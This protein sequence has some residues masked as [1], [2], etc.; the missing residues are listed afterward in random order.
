MNTNSK[1]M[2]TQC[3]K[4]WENHKYQIIKWGFLLVNFCLLVLLTISVKL[5]WEEVVQNCLM[6]TILLL[7]L[8][9]VFY[10]L[11]KRE[12]STKSELVIVGICVLLILIS[13]IVFGAYSTGIYREP[14]IQI[15]AAFVGGAITLYGVGLTIK[16]NRLAK[17]QD[18]IEKAKPNIFPID[19]QTWKSLEG[20]AKL[21]RDI[22]PQLELSSLKKTNNN[23]NAYSFAPIYLANSDLSM[24]T[25]KGIVINDK[26]YIVFKYDVVL[27]KGSTNCFKLDY[28]FELKEDINSIQLVVGDM[29]GNTYACLVSFEYGSDKRKK[30][31]QIHIMGTLET[32][33][34][35]KNLAN[36]F[37]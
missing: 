32:K 20:I 28:C 19:P 23:T 3:T 16:Y 6:A 21:E 5:P 15:S 31:K 29:L 10:P 33:P 34:L 25:L 12:K 14:F 30:F 27:L 4:W 8:I 18:D 37:N 2:K 35:D 22:E 24:C 17:E 26:D 7:S 11:I 9:A 13:A 36:V 1:K